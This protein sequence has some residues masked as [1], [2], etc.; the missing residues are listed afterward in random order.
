MNMSIIFPGL[1]LFLEQVPKSFLIGDLEITLY[2]VMIAVGMLLGLLVIFPE[3][4]RNKQNTND[5]LGM[6]ISVTFFGIIGARFAYVLLHMP[7]YRSNPMA[8][9]N[10]R[11][12][13]MSFYGGLFGGLFGGAGYAILRDVSFGELAD[14]A[15]PGILTAQAVASW[16]HFFDRSGFGGYCEWV[17]AMQL[18]LD[19]V[20]A[21][22]VSTGLREN[23]VSVEGISCIQTHPV[24]LYDF[25]WCIL[26]LVLILAG[27]RK[28][29]FEGELFFDYLTWYGFGRF[30]L[31]LLRTDRVMLPD[32]NFPVSA[33]IS[34][35]LFFVCGIL[36]MIRQSMMRKREKLLIR[37]KEEFLTAMEQAEAE[38]DRIGLEEVMEELAKVH[39][40]ENTE[41]TVPAE[42]DTEFSEEIAAIPAQN[43]E[44]ESDTDTEA[45]PEKETESAA[46][47]AEAGAE[48]EAEP[49]A[50]A[51]TA[52]YPA[53]QME[54][55]VK[56]P[57]EADG[58][59]AAPKTVGESGELK[60]AID[61]ALEDL[62]PS[63][64]DG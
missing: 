14:T 9:L 22:E 3:A 15:V 31:D 21:D 12:G 47:A 19:A 51:E 34:A 33:V 16:G 63:E 58:S 60:E 62:F 7:I 20:R 1:G 18:P 6:L 5:L 38:V 28:K 13:G 56:D 37:R 29:L 27:R 54:G 46:A 44:E 25:L 2:G 11:Q 59:P 10:L 24:F 35:I 39:K 57:S 36:L 4:K 8:I 41:E 23:L 53:A 61:Q 32:I 49:A 52:S 30:F 17:T 26:M 50:E 48:R 55:P 45:K 43:P 40:K 64:G 42:G